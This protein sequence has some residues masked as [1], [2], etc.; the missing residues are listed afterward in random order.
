MRGII[1][2]QERIPSRVFRK[3]AESMRDVQLK[4]EE[5]RIAD[6][7]A[8]AGNAKEHPAEQVEQI[9]ESMREFGNCDP[10]AVWTNADGAP[11]I[12]EGHGRLMALQKLGVDTAP[13][14]YLD[15]LTDEQRR[16]YVHIHNQTTMNSGFDMDVLAEEIASLPEFDWEA[17]GFDAVMGEEEEEK[18]KKP[19]V[20]FSEVLGEENNY[21]VLKFDNELDW[22]NAQ[23]VF[24][25]ENVK[26]LS[27]RKDGK[28][29]EGMTT[30]GLGRV[31]D[32]AKA[33]NALIGGELE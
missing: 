32:G 9:A 8:Y 33:I 2:G 17:Y 28:L 4:I 6:L 22:I 20:P 10:I 15:H 25:L 14:I 12:V 30:I 19:E 31:I 3:G 27:T 1:E 13:V 24:G 18:P 26:R 11:E 21:I 7:V 16:A 5:A 29:S 23:T